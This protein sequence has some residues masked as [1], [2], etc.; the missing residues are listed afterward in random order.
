MVDSQHKH[1][2]GD[3]DLSAEE[4]ALI[5]KMIHMGHESENP[6]P[7]GMVSN[8]RRVAIGKGIMALVR[9]VAKPTWF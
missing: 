1:I 8:P 9:A 4:I 6:T 3:R 5:Q 7:P 2:K